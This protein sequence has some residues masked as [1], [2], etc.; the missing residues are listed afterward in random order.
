MSRPVYGISERP[1]PCV[2]KIPE[3]QD[4]TVYLRQV[5][6]ILEQFK[7]A[8]TQKDHAIERLKTLNA[9][10]KAVRDAALNPSPG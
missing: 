3:G 5:N 9:L 7:T 4:V 10:L 6:N 8:P 2:Y 1:P